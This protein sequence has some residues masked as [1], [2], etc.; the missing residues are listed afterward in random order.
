MRRFNLVVTFSQ[1]K[2]K[3]FVKALQ[4]NGQS[5]DSAFELSDRTK[6]ILNQI[7]AAMAYVNDVTP[8]DRIDH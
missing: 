8:Y 3:T 1:Q 6:K 4:C 2:R 7:G 5:V